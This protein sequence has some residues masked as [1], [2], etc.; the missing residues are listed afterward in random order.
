MDE[1]FV[2]TLCHVQS[3]RGLSLGAFLAAC[4]DV[5]SRSKD[6]DPSKTMD[7][8]HSYLSSLLDLDT[9]KVLSATSPCRKSPG[10]VLHLNEDIDDASSMTHEEF[11]E[12]LSQGRTKSPSGSA[13]WLLR[14]CAEVFD[15]V[16]K[17]R[18][19]ISGL[20]P[21]E[22]KILKAD[23]VYVL[24]SLHSLELLGIRRV[25]CIG[26]LSFN[27]LS[28]NGTDVAVLR[29]LLVGLP[30]NSIISGDFALPNPLVVSLLRVLRGVDQSPTRRDDSSIILKASGMGGSHTSSD[31]VSLLV[32]SSENKIVSIAS[33]M[34]KKPPVP[35][36]L[37]LSDTVTQLEC[38]LDDI[39]GELLAH[40]IE[41][42]FEVGAADVWVTPIVMKKGRPAHTIHCLCLSD[43]N[44]ELEDRLLEALFRHTT[45]LG[46]RIYRN[47]PRAKLCRFVEVAQTPYT[48]TRREGKVD[49]KVSS[50][51]TG[52]ILSIKPEFDHCQEISKESCIPLKFVAESALSDTRQQLQQK[53][54]SSITVVAA[55]V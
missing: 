36:T 32:G 3:S 19:K 10:S 21:G 52:E 8:L 51:Q 50:F 28:M 42:L 29:E 46:V 48:A 24:G 14:T 6:A 11:H 7:G 40:V 22:T 44:S 33:P 55:R 47:L 2:E 31:V 53:E 39:T 13:E 26:P 15:C 34:I 1:F 27:P 20:P 38:N 37:W 4:I 18:N 9:N 30:V 49:V 54:A 5:V 25:V 12:L 45:T 16:I 35:S 41:L 43:K 23:L 17:I